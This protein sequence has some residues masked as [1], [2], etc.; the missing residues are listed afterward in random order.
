MLDEGWAGV[1]WLEAACPSEYGGG[2]TF[3]LPW[4]S[5][6]SNSPAFSEAMPMLQTLLS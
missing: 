6:W 3:P 5:A 4:R 1:C 2:G